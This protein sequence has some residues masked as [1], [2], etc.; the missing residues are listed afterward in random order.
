MLELV[1]HR[2][3][4]S[5]PIQRHDFV[6]SPQQAAL[7]AGTVVANDVEE[8]GVVQLAHLFQ[9]SHESADFDIRMFA[10]AREHLHLASE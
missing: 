7:F 5:Q 1:G 4:R 2:V 6:K 10:K 3:Y 8:Q 9:G